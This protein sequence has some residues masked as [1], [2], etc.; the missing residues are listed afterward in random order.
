MAKFSKGS[1]DNLAWDLVA[2]AEACQIKHMLFISAPKL[3][4]II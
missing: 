4:P 2:A 1:V 3:P